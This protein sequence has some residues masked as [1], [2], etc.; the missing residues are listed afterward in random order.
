MAYL[1]AYCT[2]VYVYGCVWVL[3]L[4]RAILFPIWLLFLTPIWC[5]IPLGE[6][7]SGKQSGQDCYDHN[8]I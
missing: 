4:L 7:V 2:Q 3:L 8:S 1:Q 6:A 5:E